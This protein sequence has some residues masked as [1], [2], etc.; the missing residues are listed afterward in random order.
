[1]RLLGNKQEG[2]AII[3][4]LMM[5]V[6]TL[7]IVMF[8][9]GITKKITLSSYML[10][11]K[12]HAKLKAESMMEKLKFYISTGKFGANFIESTF[13]GFPDRLYIDGRLQKLNDNE[14]LV[15]QGTGGMI[16]AWVLNSKVITGLLRSKG[17]SES[18]I[19]IIV[20]SLADWYDADNFR[21]VSG[22][23]S[24]FYKSIGCVYSPRN[25]NG[26]QS[27]WE[28][29]DIRGLMDNKTFNIIKNYLTLSPNWHFNVNTMDSRLLSCSMGIPPEIAKSIVKSRLNT[30][31]TLSEI[32]RITGKNYD[33]LM[34]SDFPTFT[35]DIKV[36]IKFN[37]AVER[38]YALVSFVSDNSSPYR[39][40]KWQN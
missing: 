10:M 4:A 12:L 5:S 26:I 18:R 39:V 2:S 40:L 38:V 30:P 9:V 35:L 32:S 20:D 36:Q 22:A 19:A 3:I 6:V 15:L 13:K 25:F 28:W 16:D 37:T 31:L 33:V 14:T 11:D 1:M 8:A 34:F 21:R 24:F 7:L 27:V 29:R 17:V 23:E